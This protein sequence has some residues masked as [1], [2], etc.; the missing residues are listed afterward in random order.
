MT[1]EFEGYLY[2]S[3]WENPFST[4]ISVTA[5]GLKILCLT[6]STHNGNISK[7]LSIIDQKTGENFKLNNWTLVRINIYYNWY[8]NDGPCFYLKDQEGN[9]I[10]IDIP[11]LYI[12]DIEGNK[13]C[14]D[15]TKR[16]FPN[17]TSRPRNA[18]FDLTVG[19]RVFETLKAME[20][21]SQYSS[22]EELKA[23]LKN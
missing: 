17:V 1:E 21:I 16:I 15:R 13:I 6:T 14:I 2:T 18:N 19:F 7:S 3:N 4:G 22:I 23:S 8:S 11:C 20:I 12:K 9:E 10:C 5:N